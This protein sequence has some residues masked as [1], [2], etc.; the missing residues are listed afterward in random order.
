MKE[1]K[2]R[3]TKEQYLSFQRGIGKTELFDGA[4]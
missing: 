1:W 4:R 3:L 2:P